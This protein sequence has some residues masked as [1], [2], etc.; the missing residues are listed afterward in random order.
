MNFLSFIILIIILICIILALK[1]IHKNKKEGKGCCGSCKGCSQNLEGIKNKNGGVMPP[2][3]IL[4]LI[5][6][7]TSVKYLDIFL[8][9]LLKQTF[10]KVLQKF[11][12]L[13]KELDK[14]QVFLLSSV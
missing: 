5:Q 4:L 13:H 11:Q 14:L 10:H 2:I 6:N 8:Y 7:D 12:N 1:K 9:Q 3:F